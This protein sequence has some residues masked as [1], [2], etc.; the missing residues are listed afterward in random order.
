[1]LKRRGR[2]R[3]SAFWAYVVQAMF[4][5][6]AGWMP[7]LLLGPAR[8]YAPYTGVDVLAG[9]FTLVDNTHL[10]VAVLFVL[11][12]YGPLLSGLG[13]AARLGGAEG[14][15]TL[16]R[17]ITHWRLPARWYGALI[18][19]L[20]MTAPAIA[21]ARLTGVAPETV[22][23]PSNGWLVPLVLLFHLLTI[24]TAEYGWRGTALALAQR[25]YA[26]EQASY[27]VGVLWAVWM[28]P[29]LGALYAGQAAG[30][31]LLLLL[32]GWGIYLIGASVVHTWLY[33]NTASL[34]LCMLYSAVS[35][36]VWTLSTGLMGWQPLPQ[37]VLG[38]TSWL[39]AL[40]ILRRYGAARLVRS[41]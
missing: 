11:G 13:I 32:I 24:A 37:L 26:A 30:S 10:A 6:W 1:M 4:I 8:G 23:F 16:W 22:T 20:L 12:S 29:Y 28:L 17:R 31:T 15:R 5:S 3:I 34:G 14:V 38:I 2:R 25:R 21:V 27:I 33:N 40:L 18:L 9:R 39:V 41:S 36:T 19:P 7:G 35:M